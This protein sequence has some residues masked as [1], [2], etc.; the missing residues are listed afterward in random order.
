MASDLGTGGAGFLKGREWLLLLFSLFLA[1]FIWFIHNLSL[2]YSVFLEY[3]VTVKTNFEG[4][5]SVSTSDD[6]LIIRGKT[7]GFYILSQRMRPNKRMELV[8]N[9]DAKYLHTEI[10]DD[11]AFYASIEDIKGD[12][13]ESLGNEVELEFI[14][15][16]WLNFKFPKVTSK[17]V[18]IVPKYSITCK[19]QYMQVGDIS[20]KPDS[21]IISG[22]YDVLS[23]V[24]SV[25]TES[26]SLSQLD[27]PAQGLARL[28]SIRNVTFSEMRTYYSL[29]VERY[30]EQSVTVNVTASDV[31]IGKE[32]IVLPSE[33]IVTFRRSFDVKRDYSASDF[34]YVVDYGDYLNSIDSKLVPKLLQM[35]DGVFNTSI[36]PSFVDCLLIEK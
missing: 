20:L 15:T 7:D 29:D 4:R 33:L 24:D 27:R 16:Q 18:P 5:A 28:V 3:Q 17:K 8:I 21:V 30:I 14:I 10:Y 31:P 35:P 2:P 1:F 26:I 12:I 23:S 6:V 11:D 22:G 34:P 13:V 9:T 25:L 32:L 19:D 36:A